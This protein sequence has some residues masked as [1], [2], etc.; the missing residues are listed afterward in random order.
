[1]PYLNKAVG[2]SSTRTAGKAEP[3]MITWPMPLICD[4]RCEN[5]LVAASYI[6]PRVSV[7]D[8]SARIRIGASAGF[9]LR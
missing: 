2:F 5:T 9:T 6:W 1:M 8:V 7:F 3:P 4:R